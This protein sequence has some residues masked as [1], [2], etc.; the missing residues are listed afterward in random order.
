MEVAATKLM[1]TSKAVVATVEVVVTIA[2]LLVVCE[3]GGN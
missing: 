2:K 3:G 1:K